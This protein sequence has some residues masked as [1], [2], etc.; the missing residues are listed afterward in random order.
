[1]F[2]MHG[3]EVLDSND[4]VRMTANNGRTYF[5]LDCQDD[6]SPTS[7]LLA[8][9]LLDR[10]FSFDVDMGQAGCNCNVALYM[11][12]MM[13][14][15]ELSD[16]ADCSEDPYYCDANNICGNRCEEV[17]LMEANQ[18][19]FLSTLHSENDGVGYHAGYSKF[20]RDMTGGYVG[21]DYFPDAASCIDTRY[22]FRVSIA[23]CENSAHM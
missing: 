11:V 1:V 4:A 14:N 9:N 16:W 3:G 13:Q 2:I 7:D 5:G 15:D 6:S 10:V 21:S 17:D 22:P 23:F 20:A 19:A 12:S 8:L 18:Y